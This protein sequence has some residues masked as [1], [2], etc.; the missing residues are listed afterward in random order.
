MTNSETNP[1]QTFKDQQNVEKVVFHNFSFRRG[2][3][4]IEN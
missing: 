3:D 4:L 1:H 2:G